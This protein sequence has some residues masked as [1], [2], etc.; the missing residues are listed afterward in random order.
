MRDVVGGDGE[1]RRKRRLDVSDGEN[2][3]STQ[4]GIVHEGRIH[5]REDMAKKRE[6]DEKKHTDLEVIILFM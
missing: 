2:S 4:S 3:M 6:Q 1:E 5:V